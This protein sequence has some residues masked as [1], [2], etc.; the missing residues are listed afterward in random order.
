MKERERERDRKVGDRHQQHAVTEGIC[1]CC[2][3]LD[4]STSSERTK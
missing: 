1:V 3:I 4:V 2:H